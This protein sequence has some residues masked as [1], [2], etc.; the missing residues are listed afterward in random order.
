VPV[1]SAAASKISDAY[2][3]RIWLEWCSVG[4]LG[5]KTEIPGQIIRMT[6]FTTGPPDSFESQVAIGVDS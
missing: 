1:Y 4:L 3:W 6:A 5:A 2:L